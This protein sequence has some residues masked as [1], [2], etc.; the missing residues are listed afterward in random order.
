MYAFKVTSGTL[1]TAFS[2]PACSYDKILD[3]GYSGFGP[4]KNNPEMEHVPDVGPI[5]HG[6]WLIADEPFDSPEHGPFCLRL[7]PA[8]G[9]ETYGRD[10][11]LIHGD[12]IEHP[13]K[14]SKG[15][16]CMSRV[17]REAINRGSDKELMVV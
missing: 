5:P 3:F 10:G 7:T 6:K 11:F 12:S 1:V 4:G 17:A 2:L 8:P 14:A 16:I 15:C 13:G 9:T